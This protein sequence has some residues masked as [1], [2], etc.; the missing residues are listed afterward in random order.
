MAMR[1]VATLL[2]ACMVVV[3]GCAKPPRQG[4]GTAA[5][6]ADPPA[7]SAAGVS[8]GGP[9]G[10]SAGAA[11]VGEAAV[12]APAR[13]ATSAPGCLEAIEA[14]V[15]RATGNRVLLGPAAFATTDELVLARQQPRGP[16]GRPLDGR[17]RAAT[18]VVFRLALAGGQCQIRRVDAS[19]TLPPSAGGDPSAPA[20]L[21]A[22]ARQPVAL[23]ECRCQ[24][25]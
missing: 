5:G 4:G 21:S 13:L 12:G 14:V 16:D 10:G 18:P 9:A 15:E 6:P 7:G 8:T 11:P 23:P 17:A 22:A 24:A 25:R 1:V 19:G 3:A 2:V 20:P